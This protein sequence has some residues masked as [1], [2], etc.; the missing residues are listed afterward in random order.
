MAELN[1][2]RAQADFSA[3]RAKAMFRELVAL[4]T[5]RHNELLAFDEV[6]GKLRVGG[7][8]RNR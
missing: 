5:G 1:S 2:L 7:K 4:I 6:A 3:A 8:R